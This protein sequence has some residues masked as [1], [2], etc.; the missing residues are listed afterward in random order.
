MLDQ[1]RMIDEELV[2]FQR[3]LVI[4]DDR[5]TLFLIA[6]KVRFAS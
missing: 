2:I 6:G 1:C 3:L 4:V 5:L